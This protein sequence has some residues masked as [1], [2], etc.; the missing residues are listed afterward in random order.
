MG[1]ITGYICFVS[2]V[3]LIGKYV[4]RKSQNKSVN[5]F[6]GKI[7][8]VTGYVFVLVCMIHFLLV[9]PVLAT[10]NLWVTI[11]GI[12][13]FAIA[14]VLIA[15]KYLIKNGKKTMHWHRVFSVVILCAVI[16]HIVVYFVDFNQYQ[17]SISSIEIGEIDLSK[18]ADGSYVGDCDAGYIYAKVQVTVQDGKIEEI[19]ILEHKNEHGQRAESIID[20]IVGEQ[21]LDVDA[22]S[23]A[24][25]SSLVI[26]KACEKALC[27]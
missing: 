24:S 11:W 23:G 2:F 18:V 9:I 7:H 14:I 21:R 22:V 15:S 17:Q 25:N 6:F 20:K 13:G 10:R 19:T 12:I 3:L 5:K 4:A 27:Q 26:K 1:I 16:L 8:K